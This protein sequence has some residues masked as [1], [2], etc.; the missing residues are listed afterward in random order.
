MGTIAIDFDDTFTADR[1]L[2]SGFIRTAE[3]AGHT[4]VCVTARSDTPSDTD[5][6]SRTFKAWDCVVDVVFTDRGSKLDAMEQRGLAVDIWI[7]NNPTALV[8]GYQ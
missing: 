5:Y 4:V 1:D 8:N 3:V 6:I 7:D 2:W